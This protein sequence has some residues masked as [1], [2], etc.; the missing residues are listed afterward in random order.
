MLALL[1]DEEA[2]TNKKKAKSS[3][4]AKKKKKKAVC[5]PCVITLGMSHPTDLLSVDLHV[6]LHPTCSPYILHPTSYFLLPTSYF[7]LPTS[8]RPPIGGP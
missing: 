8:Y 7:V 5:S 2:E 3:K 4:N 6:V 1:A